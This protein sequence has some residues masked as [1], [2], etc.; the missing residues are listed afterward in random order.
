MNDFKKGDK[1]YIVAGKY[2][3]HYATFVCELGP[4]DP[5]SG[6]PNEGYCLS[7]QPF[8]LSVR[9]TDIVPESD[10]PNPFSADSWQ[11]NKTA[12][13]EW[14]RDIL[15]QQSACSVPSFYSHSFTELPK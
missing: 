14:A 12:I 11:A 6:E 10:A 4:V 15:I 1:V 3:G 8:G 9:T 2:T 7:M 13:E 5:L